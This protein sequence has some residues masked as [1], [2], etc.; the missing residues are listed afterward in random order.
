MRASYAILETTSN[1][2]SARPL[3]RVYENCNHVFTGTSAERAVAVVAAYL[4]RQLPHE[5]LPDGLL[6]LEACALIG[7]NPSAL[8]IPWAVPYRAPEIELRARRRGWRLLEGQSVV[9]DPTAAELVTPPRPLLDGGPLAPQ[10][11]GLRDGAT[12]PATPQGRWPICRW[13]FRMT[14][15]EK[16][17]MSRARAVADAMA[18]AYRHDGASENLFKLASL[19]EQL[20]VFGV[21]HYRDV[22]SLIP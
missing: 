13:A 5:R 18:V 1:L 4:E 15:S 19:I 7:G 10:G 11:S 16:G 20:D 8:L 3:Y 21:R 14:S 22:A 2:G 9:V 6:R 17:Y 12:D